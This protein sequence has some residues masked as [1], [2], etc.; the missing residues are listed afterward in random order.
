MEDFGQRSNVDLLTQ[1]F[2]VRDA[3]KRYAE[4]KAA[5]EAEMNRVL[6]PSNQKWIEAIRSGRMTPAEAAVAAHAEYDQLGVPHVNTPPNG[7]GGGMGGPAEKTVQVDLPPD[8]NINAHG[9]EGGYH[10]Q[11]Q[12]ELDGR[13]MESNLTPDDPYGQNTV[14]PSQL[15]QRGGMTSVARSPREDVP[16][17]GG[18]MTAPY[19]VRDMNDAKT[20]S[21]MQR[22]DPVATQ[23]ERNVG[24]AE[25]ANIRAGGGRDV[26]KIKGE[27]GIQREGMKG[28]Q[29]TADRQEKARQFD[30]YL[31]WRYASLE[32]Q[33]QITGMIS[34][35]KQHIASM[36]MGDKTSGENLKMDVGLLEKINGE[37]S[38]LQNEMV[39]SSSQPGPGVDP[40]LREKSKAMIED[41]Q[42]QAADLMLSIDHQMRGR[43]GRGGIEETP[44]SK[45]PWGPGAGGTM[46]PN[47]RPN[48]RQNAGGRNVGGPPP[49]N[50]D[51]DVRAPKVIQ[52]R[53]RKTGKVAPV[54]ADKIDAAM[55]EVGEEEFLK[56]YEIAGSTEQE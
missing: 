43:G 47:R 42:M 56:M 16:P 2:G 6:H 25:V 36:S 37:I 41:L 9:S 19:T 53:D 23:R 26:A 55:Q 1:G 49:I 45:G 3:N 8:T 24:N 7:M 28:D 50:T 38:R 27:F 30:D 29:K 11:R 51:T 21:G 22:P 33:R 46:G 20:I 48:D 31:K 15:G 14:Q 4:E 35:A 34:K 5:K 18:G 54:P 44:G 13:M 32:N 17:S 39:R 52:L 12:S 40:E 10:V